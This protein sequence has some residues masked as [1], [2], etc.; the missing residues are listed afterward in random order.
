MKT[1]CCTIFLLVVM[2]TA[3]NAQQTGITGKVTDPTGAVIAGASVI[4][5]QAGGAA[6][7]AT[8]NGSGIYAV[9]SLIASDYTV[10]VTARGFATV[11]QRLS[12]LVGQMVE[13]DIKLPLATA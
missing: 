8:T 7:T 12:I 11:E 4:V 3:A 13:A 5:K 10:T 6:F 9:P 2:A 1:L